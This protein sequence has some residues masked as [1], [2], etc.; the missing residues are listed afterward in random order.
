MTE[1]ATE[2]A[3]FVIH[4][5][6]GTSLNAAAPRQASDPMKV[7]QNIRKAMEADKLMVEMDGQLYLIPLTS[8]KY[9]QVSPAPES[10][11]DGV[12]RGATLMS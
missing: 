5:N 12:I 3:R 11:P 1:N 4:F 9:V 2:M 8:V 10:L 6:D 7:V